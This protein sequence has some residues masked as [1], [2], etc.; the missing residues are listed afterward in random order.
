M[1]EKTTPDWE[2]IERHYRAGLLSI[3]EIAAS[4]G[5]SHVAIQKR[6]KRDGWARDLAAKIKAKADAL[7]TR[8]VVTSVVTTDQVVTERAIVDANAQAVVDVRLGHRSD[9]NRC[10]RLANKLLDE[11]EAL[12]D[13]QGTIKSL[14]TQLKDGGHEDGDAMADMLALA[15]KIGALPSRTKTMKELAETLKTLVALERQAW[16]IDDQTAEESY[17][18]RLARLMGAGQ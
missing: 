7:V 14:I 12:T 13:E 3:R 15:N 2:L 11:L 9:I 4:C 17:E 6:A 5:V 8:E 16:S 18:D 10:R 1:T